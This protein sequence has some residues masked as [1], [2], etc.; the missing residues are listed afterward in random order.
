MKPIS[1]N[2]TIEQGTSYS[3][4]LRIADNAGSIVD[5][6]N[7]DI[8]SIMRKEWGS[9]NGTSFTISKIEPVAGRIILSLSAE[10]TADIKAGVYVYDVIYSLNTIVNKVVSG[11]V[12]V[13]PTSSSF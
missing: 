7:A 11:L 2:H 3:Y 12:T 5:V 6:T 9:I 4:E 13:N 1:Y 8:R 10:D